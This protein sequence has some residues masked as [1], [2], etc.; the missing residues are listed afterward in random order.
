MSEKE[1]SLDVLFM[2]GD[3][4]GHSI[5]IDDDSPFNSESYEKLKDTHT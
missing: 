4:I 2:P 1:N 5:P 3:F